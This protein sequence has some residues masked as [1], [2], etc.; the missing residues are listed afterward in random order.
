MDYFELVKGI[1]NQHTQA[2]VQ[3]RRIA[4]LVE[5]VAVQTKLINEQRE[6]IELLKAQVKGVA[7][8]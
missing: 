7:C 3:A 6:L 1:T 2:V 8:E 5:L 4:E